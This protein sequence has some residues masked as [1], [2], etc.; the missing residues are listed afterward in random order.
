MVA[1][2]EFTKMKIHFALALLGV[3]FALHPFLDRFDERG[4]LYL[5][6]DLKVF[7]AYSLT[8][9]L[10]SIA[11][12]LYA[13]SLMGDRSHSWI[14][15]AG[16][17]AYAL[18]I[19]IVPIYAGLF[20]SARLADEVAL[21]HL[22][23]AAPAVAFGLG[24]SWLTLTQLVAWRLRGRLGERDRAAKIA[25]LAK[26]EIDSLN[27]A[28]DLFESEHYD[29][30]VIEAWRALEARLRQRLL[31]RK[32]VTPLETPHALIQTATRKKILEEPILGVV[33]ELRRNVNIA[34]STEPLPREAAVRSLS[35]VRHILSIVPAEETGAVGS[36][37]WAVG[38]EEEARRK[39]PGKVDGAD[40]M[41]KVKGEYAARALR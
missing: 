36:G 12:Y 13:V 27:Q 11:V 3:L 14:E 10:L 38:S 7:Y 37:Q 2:T 30:S 5:G 35:A 41:A 32:I 31:S 25:Q 16:N 8:A 33:A 15:R 4:F 1:M 23:W 29:L 6:Y 28:S 24:L 17:Y 18:A 26:Q 21:S 9:V 22:A 39:E 34:V 20:L 40:V 19:L